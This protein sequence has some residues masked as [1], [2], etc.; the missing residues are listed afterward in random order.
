[1]Q[2]AEESQKGNTMEE[3]NK[4]DDEKRYQKGSTI[5]HCLGSSSRTHDMINVNKPNI[6][7]KQMKWMN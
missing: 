3:I 2:E 6:I 7:Q 4:A 1:M 5:K